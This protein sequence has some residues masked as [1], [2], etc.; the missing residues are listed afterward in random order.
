MPVTQAQ[1]D[2]GR[3][4]V[5]MSDEDFLALWEKYRHFTPNELNAVEPFYLITAISKLRGHVM[6]KG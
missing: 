5:K 2:R 4:L 6:A 1:L 3:K